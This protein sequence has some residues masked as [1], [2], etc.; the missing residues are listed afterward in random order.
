MIQKEGLA[1]RVIRI[2]HAAK[3]QLRL[4]YSSATALVFP[5]LEEGFGF[6][7]LEAMSYGLP[8]VTSNCSS[9][10]EVAGDAALLVDPRNPSEIAEAM[11]RI[12]EDKSLADD[13]RKKGFQRAKLF[14]WE[15]CAKK[16]WEVYK[17]ILTQF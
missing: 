2:G 9:M 7:I 1:D 17:E 12:A 13:L 14:S 8:V 16:T 11:R 6:P 3:D 5:S 10:P 4:L 15:S